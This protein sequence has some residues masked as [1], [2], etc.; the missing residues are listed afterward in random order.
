MSDHQLDSNPSKV[1]TGGWKGSGL[2]W[3]VMS[4]FFTEE[5]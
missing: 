5:M 3:A 4:R 2:K 1:M